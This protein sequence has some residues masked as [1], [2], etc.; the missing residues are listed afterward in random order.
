MT[1]REFTDAI[2]KAVRE[3]VASG[4]DR[5]EIMAELEGVLAG[6]RDE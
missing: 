2:E 4:L 6:M 5:D 3:A 1:M